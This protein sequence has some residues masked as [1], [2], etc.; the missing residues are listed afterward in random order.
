MAKNRSVPK[1]TGF[2]TVPHFRAWLE[3]HHDTVPELILR[4]YKNHARDHGIGY[5]DALDEALAWGWI[6]GVRRRLDEVSFTVRF[7]PRRP[8]S[9]WSAVNIKRVK[10]LQAQGRMRPPGLAAFEARSSSHPVE[11]SYESR[12]RALDPASIRKFRSNA[13]AWQFYQAQAP[14]YRRITA[15]WVISAK[16]EETRVRRLGVLMAS[17]AQGQLIPPLM[18]SSR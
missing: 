4:C 16:R 11:Y 18:R 13:T 17:S 14:W 9:K 1:P 6:D 15:F 12:S 5:F 8:R 3:T 10:A 7:T 2:L